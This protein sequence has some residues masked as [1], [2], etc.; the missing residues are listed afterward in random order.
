MITENLSTLKI[1]KLTQAQYDRELAAGRIDENALYLTPDEEITSIENGGTGASTA[2]DARTNLG[3]GKILFKSTQTST[4][5][6]DGDTNITIA[7]MSKYNVLA[8]GI[9]V[10]FNSSM[11][12]LYNTTLITKSGIYYYGSG[13]GL[14]HKPGEEVDKAAFFNVNLRMNGDT[15]TS[16]QMFCKE[17]SNTESGVVQIRSI[18]G[19]C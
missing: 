2:E 3:I 15:I 10:E 5:I 6:K 1:N 9:Y 12:V 18:Y 17:D 13:G 16:V 19:L 8:C 4:N 7:D 11:T 14:L